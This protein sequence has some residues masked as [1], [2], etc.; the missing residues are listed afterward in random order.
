M[1]KY[2]S[3]Y[4]IIF[5][6]CLG[7]NLSGQEV[8]TKKNA[9]KKALKMYD[10]ASSSNSNDLEKQEVSFEKIILKYP[11]FVDPH[12]DLAYVYYQQG[13]LAKAREKVEKAIELDPT[14]KSNHYLILANYCKELLDV[15]CE[16]NALLQFLEISKSEKRNAKIKIRLE[17]LEAKKEILKDIEKITIKKLP[18][19]INSIE[20]PEYKPFLNLENDHIV[21]TR[22]VHGQED[23]YESYKKGN[24]W[25]EAVPIADLNTPG[26]EGAHT[27]SADGKWIIFTKCDAPKRYKSCDLYIAKNNNGQWDEAKFMSNINT[28]SWESQ[29]SFSPDGNT[30][31]FSS[32]RTG[33]LGGKDLY[34]IEYKDKA[35]GEVQ[36]LGE[37]INTTGNE[38]SPFMH[39][40]G[41]TLY[42][43]SNGH[44]GLGGQDLFMS[45]RQFDGS[46][47]EPLNM[48]PSI[49]ST[50]DEGGIFI[51]LQGEFAYFSKTEKMENNKLDSDIYR[52]KLP[53]K[54]KPVSSSYVKISLID[55]VSNQAISGKLQITEVQS[56]QQ[57]EENIDKSGYLLIVDTKKTFQ[58]TIEKE[59][60]IF[61]SEKVVFED[62]S[63]QL[64][65]I[66]YKIL[67]NPIPQEVKQDTLPPVALRNI[68]FETGKATLLESSFSELGRLIKLMS[69]NT[70]M[71]VLIN[72]HT[73]NVGN[74]EDNVILSRQRAESVQAYLINKGI[75]QGKVSIQA[76]GE[77][78]PIQSNETSIGRAANRRIEFQIIYPN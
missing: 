4:C 76:F 6:S 75:P 78:R 67:L 53:K 66:E 37:I 69:E 19:S 52:F 50:K 41:Q 11:G 77:S 7:S 14:Y 42:F 73:D 31:Y 74:E 23:F 61:H 48:G 59:N 21:F 64:A 51:D 43:M 27:I 32:S 65:P 26:N 35:W 3:I 40:D 57:R 39:P 68:E 20:N 12:I 56:K 10:K 30:I 44:P 18:S 71:N 33:G 8:F 2:F 1:L 25:S 49:N 28:N 24:Q 58:L 5:F 34:F 29:A 63:E 16:E 15:S 60:Y 47:S 62:D 55:A 9:P 22:R 38:E 70:K 72:G 17:K 45:S 13:L 54:F 46:W 36:N